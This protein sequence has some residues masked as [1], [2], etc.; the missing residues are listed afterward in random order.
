VDEPYL[1]ASYA[2]A[3]I[4]AG[5]QD[6]AARGAEH[7]ATMAR[8]EGAGTYWPVKSSTP[9]HGWGRAGHIETTALAVQALA[10]SSDG[11]SRRQLIEGGLLF[12]INQKDRYGVWH[13]TQATVN[14]LDAFMT[15][16]PNQMNT[17]GPQPAVEVLVNGRHVKSVELPRATE[18]V[19]LLPVD[20]SQ[21]LSMGKNR[22]EI[23][24]SAGS[25]G[26]MAQVVLSYYAPW[27]ARKRG[28]EGAG[29]L[30]LKVGYDRSEAKAGEEI[31]C[32]VEAERKTARGFGMMLAEIGLPPGAEADRESLE[33]AVKE[34]AWAVSR[35]D[36][37]P[38]RVVFYLWPIKNSIQFK[39]K[40]RPRFGLK[41]KSAP[42]TLY[43]YYNPDA[44]S[45]VAPTRFIIH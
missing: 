27:D 2:L 32:V 17:A 4:S 28:S 18:P 37:M 45:V 20:L 7:L 3:A 13:S 33:Q 5:D 25:A 12:L 1:A 43:D 42:S 24:R 38:D 16:V 6:R 11:A 14:V 23:R 36:V 34:S 41:A 8:S 29:A 9:F 10:R 15:L 26:A 44:R 22:V 19:N 39:F 21:Y 35:Y 40:F 31:T 30:D